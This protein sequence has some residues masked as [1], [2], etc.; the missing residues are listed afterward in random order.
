MFLQDVRQEKLEKLHAEQLK[1]EEDKKEELNTNKSASSELKKG[2]KKGLDENKNVNLN[3]IDEHNCKEENATKDCK[4]E[5]YINICD[6]IKS[7][8]VEIIS[9]EY[10]PKNSS[11][12]TSLMDTVSSNGSHRNDS[13]SGTRLINCSKFGDEINFSFE[14]NRMDQQNSSNEIV[15]K[16]NSQL[17]GSNETNQTEGSNE[18][19]QVVCCDENVATET[20]ND[21][22]CE[23]RDNIDH[24]DIPHASENGSY[25]DEAAK[26][27]F[28]KYSFLSD[29]DIAPTKNIVAGFKVIKIEDQ[30]NG[31]FEVNVSAACLKVS[32]DVNI[33][34]EINNDF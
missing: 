26:H 6:V 16:L 8:K 9:V 27:E 24:E 2:R 1:A 10:N 4:A 3:E 22:T 19:G 5:Q 28:V 14:I 34:K 12:E 33:T 13:S 11:G 23:S 18:I 30:E 20:E 21:G 29:K 17:D 25:I 31:F 15:S 7:S 32:G